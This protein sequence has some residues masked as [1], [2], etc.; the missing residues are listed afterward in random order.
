MRA[1]NVVNIRRMASKTFM[2][3]WMELSM[4]ERPESGSAFRQPPCLASL[5]TPN[6]PIN[7]TQGGFNFCE[8]HLMT[9]AGTAGIVTENMDAITDV[10][11]SSSFGRKRGVTSVVHDEWMGILVWCI[12]R[13]IMVI[14]LC[15]KLTRG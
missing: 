10:A 14:E 9:E 8:V 5:L 2:L 11:V 3:V 12:M 7:M 15:N 13:M 4:F 6:S 1:D